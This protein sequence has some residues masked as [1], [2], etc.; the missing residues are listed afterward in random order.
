MQASHAHSASSQVPA[1][2]HSNPPSAFRPDSRASEQPADHSDSDAPS[3]SDHSDALDRVANEH[4][5]MPA[6]PPPEE[7]ERRSKFQLQKLLNDQPLEI[8][9]KG[10]K[11]GVGLLDQLNDI[12]KPR[13][14]DSAEATMWAEK[15]EKIKKQAVKSRTVVGVVGNTGA[16]KSSV[17]NAMLEKERLVPTN[18]MRACTA[19]ITEI[20][21]NDSNIPYRAEIEF[22]D[23]AD[24]QRE[25][26]ILFQELF[27]GS[28]HVSHDCTN[29]DSEAGVAWAKI[30]AVYPQ[31]TKEMLENGDP[32]MLM[33]HENA[34]VLGTTRK[35]SEHNNL[36]FYRKLQSVMDTKEKIEKIGRDGKKYKVKEPAYWP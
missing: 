32:D 24:W 9:E 8:L 15:I 3:S 22:I 10:V 27:D 30:K 1:S 5:H 14:A 7:E 28:G 18:C 33:R 11:A 16:G 29:E 4:A 6:S 25:L 36:V 19:V 12:F 26:D 34:R 13:L 2:R 23:R 20:S 17:I 31:I 21:Y 35:L